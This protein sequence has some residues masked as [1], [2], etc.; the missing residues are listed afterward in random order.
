MLSFEIEKVCDMSEKINFDTSLGE[1]AAQYPQVRDILENYELDYCCGGTKNI[2]IAAQ[3]KNIDLLHFETLLQKIIEEAPH[4]QKNKKWADESLVDIVNHIQST[5]HVLAWE[6]LASIKT[7]LGMLIQVHGE[8]HGDFLQSLDNIFEDLKTKLEKHLKMEEDI[9]FAY[10]RTPDEISGCTKE[11]LSELQSEHQETA[12]IL[13]NIKSFTSNYE[14]PDYACASFAKLYA[15]LETLT[16][17][18]HVHIHLENTVLFPRLEKQ[19][20]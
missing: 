14:L 10:V 3:E 18:L 2:K 5:H 7:V 6:K 1:F 15:D 20:N 4:T 8:K 11:L 9:V 19:L 17:D 12:D 13:T 16:D